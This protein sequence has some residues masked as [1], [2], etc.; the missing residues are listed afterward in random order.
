MMKQNFFIWYYTK[1]LE[2]FLETEKNLISFFGRY[3]SIADLA[4]TFFSPWKRDVAFRY[5]R[6]L[7][8]LKSLEILIDNLLSRLIGGIVRLF[9]ILAGLAVLLASFV[10]GSAL[11]IIWLIP[12]IVFLIP[13][14]KG[15]WE[16]AA[17][18]LAVMFFAVYLFF[19]ISLYRHF[20]KSSYLGMDM[21]RLKKQK[22][23]ERV[24]NR[25][26]K[27]ASEI[28]TKIFNDNE[29]L[30]SFLKSIDLE[31][32]DFENILAYE[33][34][35]QQKKENRNRFWLKANLE[36]IPPIG[37][38]WKYAYTPHLDNYAL[39]LTRF[40]PTDY[41]ATELIGR[42][43]ELD[44]IKLIL[45]RADQNS[46]LL[47]GDAGSGK[48]TLVHYLA[49]IIR[50]GKCDDFLKNKRVLLVDLGRVISDC[51]NEGKDAEGTLRLM[52]GEAAYAGNVIIVIE[53]IENYLG[54][55]ANTFH[56]D[57]SFVMGE[58]LPLPTFQVIAT[59]TQKEYHRLIEK[60]ENFMKYF[61]VVEMVEPSEEETIKIILQ[62][63]ENIEKNRVI[64]TYQALK[65][66][67]TYS[68]QYHWDV[69]LPERAIDLA[70]E[71]L[72]FWEKK[73]ACPYVSPEVV[74]E[75]L[76]LKTKIPHGEVQGDERKKL[77]N[78]EEVLHQRVIG[79]EEAIREV[80][81]ALRRARSGIS[82]PKRPVGSFLFLGPTGVGKTETAKALA[83]SYFGDEE[84]MIRFDMS[85]FQN[86][87]SIDRL[88]GS[89]NLNQPGQLVSLVKD[90]P[91]SILLLDEI[92]KSYP[93]I[94]NL[95]L[96]VLDEG[97]VTDVFGEKA[98]FRN[99]IIIATSNVGA[100][101]I[102]ELT[103]KGESPEKIS[104]RVIDYAVENNIFRLEFLNRFDGI[105]YFRPLSLEETR[106]VTKLL[107]TKFGRRLKK[108]KNIDIAFDDQLIDIIIERGYNQ[109]FG[110]RS[111]Y[112][113]IE[114]KIENLV[115]KKIIAGEAKRGEKI[116]ITARDF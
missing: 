68:E 16:V 48:L 21:E 112:R 99:M 41:C 26:G 10:F 89:T 15:Y 87:L 51:L 85:E 76:S 61:E 66:I 34:D 84:K 80:A 27:S 91:F 75:F 2:S 74:D 9:V 11:F 39:D 24:Y 25:L 110:A 111:I 71:A 90:H 50:L 101:L 22:W 62:K 53:N 57:V 19:V 106:S 103:E 105:I 58:F 108:E 36:E 30:K 12:P 114:D 49:K 92:E 69:P 52:F 72:M 38:H 42:K 43:D 28:D 78:L 46:V 73:P 77:L 98:N 83:E 47:T 31:A 45:A 8:P 13:L 40:D 79:Q 67:I 5:W 37:K 95:F 102:K 4:A 113:F 44:I 54:K 115:A 17:F 64:F 81:E 32:K 107:L 109:T 94:L 65:R 116:S 3:F 23:F 20:G 97:Y 6:G 96:Q 1:G 100:P 104:A 63:F 86:P 35:F 18:S 70:D 88:V 60:H 59:S 93:D 29:Y 55:E 56:P 14:L 33:A 7:R 82:N